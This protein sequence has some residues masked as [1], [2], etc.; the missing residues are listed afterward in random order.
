MQKFQKLFENLG[1]RS[2]TV[3][4]LFMTS[5]M[6]LWSQETN[7]KFSMTTQMFLNE[8]NAQKDAAAHGP[9]RA[10]W[11]HQ[12]PEKMQMRKARRLIASPDTIA[13]VAYIS[14][15]IYLDDMKSL[16]QVRSLGVEV[17][18]T[19]EPQ[20][21]VTARVPVQ[22]LE[23]LADID[24]V[25][26]I[27]VARRMRPL[28]DAA[29]QKT[30]V[31]DVLAHSTDAISA[32][33]D[34]QFDGTGVVLG[35]IDTGIDFQ[36]IA[37]KDKDGNSRIKRAYVYNGTT[38]KEYTTITA[39][40]PTT[41][42]EAEDHGTHT[43]TT[44]GGSSVVVSGTTVTVTDNHAMAT[45]GG[46]APGADLY[47]AG[48]KDL[49]DTHIYNALKKMVAY[50]DSQG[51][52]LVV[53]NS[54]GSN[55][56]P[57]DGSG[58]LA[59]LVSQYFGDSHPGH[60]ILFASSNDA[61]RASGSENGGFFV[62]KKSVTSSSPLG[63]IMRTDQYGGEYYSGI[64]ANAWN[65]SNSTKL[66]CKIHV[67]G[68]TG[69][70][71]RTWTVT[72]STE[73][74]SGL[75]S[76]YYGS[77]GVDIG[78]ENGKYCLTVHSDP[79]N[80]LEAVGDYTLAIEVYPATGNADINMWAGDWTYFTG[81]LTTS[82]HTWTVGTDDMC[83]S[84]EST[85]RDAISIGA[86]VSKNSW[87]AY[88]GRTYTAGE[89]TLGDIAY[90]SSYAT[91]E[92]S[93]TGE[94]YPWISAPGARLAA[95]VNHFHTKSVDEYSYYSSEYATSLVVNSNK[96]PYAMM[97]GTSMAA[98]VVAGIVALWLQAANSVGKSLT[99]NDVKD[100]MAETA[101]QDSYTT[102]RANATH[103]GKGKIDA[104]AGI[105][106]ILGAEPTPPASYILVT[107]ASTLSAGDRVLVT[108]TNGD[109]RYVLSTTQQT[110][111]RAATE[112][113]TLNADGT[114]VPSSS[115]QIIT[116]EKDGDNFLFNVGNGYLYAASSSNNYLRTKT[117][118]DDNAKAT[119]SIDEAANAA[120]KFQGSYSRNLLCFNRGAAT[121]IFSCYAG[122]S[123]NVLLPKI[124]RS[125]EDDDP[126]SISTV[127]SDTEHPDSG[128]WYDLSGQRLNGKWLNGKTAKGIYIHNGKKV[129]K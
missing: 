41:D 59:D 74:F 24:S 123:T 86:Y 75:G 103:F 69:A 60:I 81:H 38:A 61:G 19:F 87:K 119:I 122:T 70:I 13:G 33:I 124:Y 107:D 88:S 27:K 23:K 97:E 121:K 126:I 34:S 12:I 79:Y 45:Y 42:E 9:R 67:L 111:N 84:D 3:L 106:Y 78:Q 25:T 128:D 58:E 99:V 104:L 51:K 57:R 46:M 108:Y 10:P 92:Q 53:S 110:N 89:Y 64:I 14:C 80:P 62:K 100:I 22:Q 54:W 17:E 47:L 93:P 39:A 116:L 52:P 98:P 96:N 1:Q 18:E 76:Y 82:G 83:V 16:D 105:Q 11:K 113:V 30:N 55:W 28:T 6:M 94:A 127:S 68:S 117:T 95:G 40:S 5:F 63:T 115:A 8:L 65:A 66:N 36:H 44:A 26:R 49:D 20:N 73:S 112:D 35:I 90:F 31:D 102:T 109:S 7:K 4:V 43:A 15:F 29:R 120:I 32:G 71:R 21:F 91:A 72:S 2:A 37:F 125:V 85:I 118:A 77:L 129:V 48:I 56:G 114:I 50:A 101:I